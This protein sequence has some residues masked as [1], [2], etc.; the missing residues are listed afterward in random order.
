MKYNYFIKNINIYNVK[1]LSDKKLILL[2][3]FN[4]FL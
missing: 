2:W 4:Y 1:M 3:L